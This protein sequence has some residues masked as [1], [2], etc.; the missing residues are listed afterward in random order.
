MAR[1]GYGWSQ[2][3]RPQTQQPTSWVFSATPVRRRFHEIERALRWFPASKELLETEA[4]HHPRWQIYCMGIYSLVVVC[5]SALDIFK[6]QILP[7]KQNLNWAAAWKVFCLLI[8]AECSCWRNECRF[9]AR[10]DD[11]FSREAKLIYINCIHTCIRQYINRCRWF[12]QK[13][14]QSEMQINKFHI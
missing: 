7:R 2:I 10:N 1:L 6:L 14:R 12:M 4:Q 11:E 8:G 13:C 9:N 3:N 5:T